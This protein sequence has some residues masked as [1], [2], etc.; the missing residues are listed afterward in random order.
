M[1]DCRHYEPWKCKSTMINMAECYHYLPQHERCGCEICEHR[2]GPC[3]HKFGNPEY[4]K[5]KTIDIDSN[6]CIMDNES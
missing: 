3:V 2:G 5:E 4:H 1:A 6:L